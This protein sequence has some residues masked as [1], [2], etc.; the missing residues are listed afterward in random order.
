MNPSIGKNPSVKPTLAKHTI[1]NTDAVKTPA[2]DKKSM[3]MMEQVKNSMGNFIESFGLELC[4]PSFLYGSQFPINDK[5]YIKGSYFKGKQGSCGSGRKDSYGKYT[6]KHAGS[7]IYAIAG[8]EVH[9][10]NEGT[11]FEEINEYINGLTNIKSIWID[12]GDF[13]GRYCEIVPEIGIKKGIKVTKG[14]LI[15]KVADLPDKIYGKN[16]M[17]HFE[18]YSKEAAKIQGASL[19]VRNKLRKKY[20]LDGT[21]FLES[22][23]LK[24]SNSNDFILKKYKSY[25]KLY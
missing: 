19:E 7:D 2:N 10:I 1:G 24:N 14:Q 13:V 18:Y 4:Y 15:G 22:L 16:D 25:Y 9:A 21:K 12:H 11:V 8:T 6:R 5:E 23:R 3:G 17:L 20:L